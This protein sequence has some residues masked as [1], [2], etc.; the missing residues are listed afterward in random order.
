MSRARL[1]S[2]RKRDRRL[3]IA[4]VINSWLGKHLMV[5]LGS[6]PWCLQIRPELS[7][8]KWRVQETSTVFFLM[9]S[10]TRAGRLTIGTNINLQSITKRSSTKHHQSNRLSQL[11][12]WNTPLQRFPQMEAGLEIIK[13]WVS[14]RQPKVI[15]H[16]K[17]IWPPLKYV[18][19]ARLGKTNSSTKD[20]ILTYKR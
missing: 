5:V 11:V 18:W 4:F 2:L 6:R 17:L 20:T 8:T 12:E 9:G 13:L 3:W 14:L 16:F 7:S 1:S 15:S 10:Q 19:E